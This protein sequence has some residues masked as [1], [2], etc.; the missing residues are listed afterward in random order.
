MIY[1][2]SM[3]RAVRYYP[4]RPALSVGDLSLSFRQ[5]HNRV[6][7]RQFWT[8][9]LQHSRWR[10]GAKLWIVSTVLLELCAALLKSSMIRS[11]KRTR[12]SFRSRVPEKT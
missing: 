8:R 9:Y 4:E 11:Y 1:V 2:H 6:K 3:A 7:R 12:S 10:T 5:L